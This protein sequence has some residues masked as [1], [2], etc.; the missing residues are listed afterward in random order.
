MEVIESDECNS[1]FFELTKLAD[2]RNYEEEERVEY[3][4]SEYEEKT[5]QIL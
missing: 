1:D 4:L 3:L 5:L 2:E